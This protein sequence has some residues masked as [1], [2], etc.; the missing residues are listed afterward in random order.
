MEDFINEGNE[1]AKRSVGLPRVGLSG[2]AVGS[3]S[4]SP[5]ADRRRNLFLRISYRNLLAESE[6]TRRWFLRNVFEDIG[7]HRDGDF[8]RPEQGHIHP[9]H[10]RESV[11]RHTADLERH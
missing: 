5:D 4:L 3:P 9:D 1:G 2:L 8:R 7:R 6:W 10:Q 11:I